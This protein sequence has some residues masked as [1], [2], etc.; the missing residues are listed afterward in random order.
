M[1]TSYFG[2]FHLLSIA[3]L[4]VHSLIR[5]FVLF[6]SVAQQLRYGVLATN[7]NATAAAHDDYDDDDF[8]IH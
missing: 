6:F 3:C 4:L 5:T 8:L 7:A 2:L 1:S